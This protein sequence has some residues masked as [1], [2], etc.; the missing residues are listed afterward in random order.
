[1]DD[2]QLT[3][4]EELGMIPIDILSNGTKKIIP[5]MLDLFRS[6]EGSPL[7]RSKLMVVGFESVGKTTILDCLFPQCGVLTMRG[8]FG[9]T[10]HFTLRGNL[11]TQHKSES[12][13]SAAE[14]VILLEQRQWDVVTN[15]K[16]QTLKLTKQKSAKKEELDLICRDKEMFKTWESRLKRVCKNAA[17]HGIEIQA[18]KIEN[19]ITSDYFRKRIFADQDVGTLEVSV[20]DFAGQAEYYN[21]HHYFLSARTVFLVLWKMS[22]G[23]EKGMK[24]LEFWFTSL[25]TH[26]GV[27]SPL[28]AAQTEGTYFSIFVVGTHLDD[29]SV[30]R[31]E[32]AQREEKAGVLARKCGLTCPLHYHEVSCA[33]PKMENIDKVYEAINR[34]ILGHSYMGERVPKN[35]T[36]IAALLMTEREKRKAT[37]QLQ[38]MELGGLFK[39][40]SE[41]LVKRALELLS[42]W[43]ECA[44]FA[45]PPELSSIVILDPKFLASGILADLFTSD[46]TFRRMRKDGVVKH[47]DLAQ[48]WKRFKHEGMK[49][50]DFS[51][52][53]V[54]FMTLLVKLGVCFVM[55]SDRGR[56]F[57]EQRSIIP[58]LLPERDANDQFGLFRLQQVWPNDAPPSK[59]VQIER[60]LKFRVIPSELVSRLL[61]HLHPHIQE[62]LVWKNECVIM[63]Q[64]LER[65]QGWIRVEEAEK[66]F[67]V[68]IRGS[69]LAECTK[70][71]DFIVEQVRGVSIG[72]SK[73]T[74][75]EKIR[76]PHYSGGAEID[77]EDAK[78]EVG[79][80]PE[81]RKLACPETLLP[82]QAEQL[83]VRAGLTT[84][85][86]PLTGKISKTESSG[87]ASSWWNLHS[88]TLL[89]NVYDK[90]GQGDGILNENLFAKFRLLFGGMNVNFGRVER[91]YGINNPQLRS[92]FEIKRGMIEKQQ[93]GNPG[94]F[95]KEG[96]RTLPDFSRR[97]R[98]F[99]RLAAKMASFRRE[100]N[101]GTHPFVV[102]MVHGTSESAAF[103]V[104]EGG[105]G[106][107]AAVDDGYYGRGMYF[108]SDVR[109]ASSYATEVDPQEQPGVKV[110]LV[111]MVIPGNPYPVTEHPFV[112]PFVHETNKDGKLVRRRN[113][114]GL[115]GQACKSGYQSHITV[116]DSEDIHT[117][118]PIEVEDYDDPKSKRLVSDELVVFEAAQ[119]LPLFLVYYREPTVA[120]PPATPTVAASPKKGDA[121]FDSKSVCGKLLS[122]EVEEVSPLQPNLQP[123]SEENSE[124]KQ[125][126]AQLER[127]LEQKEREITKLRTS[128]SGQLL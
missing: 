54:T 20:W 108:T 2:F 21:N 89:V 88:T 120:S 65:S 103:R 80:Q 64:E 99:M 82:I 116:V 121:A 86:P 55:D 102:P 85:L 60:V 126:I 123:L 104:V 38:I 83:L 96:W 127:S 62:G 19:G 40:Y 4:F 9:S 37:G 109:Y 50:E 18:R 73:V 78:R 33:A 113:P 119:V 14:K 97:R 30:N 69:E 111:V 29:P 58:A 42:L 6:P 8:V 34:T 51:S 106:T 67:V 79:L 68:V 117:A 17:T 28:M 114:L 47:S 52:L 122:L 105:F 92:A 63:V 22:E 112:V 32:K 118:F 71:L 49:E 87:L 66:R 77:V 11:L 101:D 13:D 100:F 115:H 10:V 56:P 125:R 124:L 5:Y 74:W 39:V 31:A 93:L 90:A 45:S 72:G 41:G 26:L 23:T 24:G 84:L 91:V 3:S 76:S 16:D 44:Y 107:V 61:A 94:L 110:F 98:M 46:D 81:R 15:T 35:Y 48:I 59:P 75:E 1:M 128:L 12:E 25:A 57:M 27:S 36:D 43:G 7:F 70:L 53:C 95:R